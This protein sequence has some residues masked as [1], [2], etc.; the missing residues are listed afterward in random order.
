MDVD[1]SFSDHDDA[2][3]YLGEVAALW[4]V[5]VA[6]LLIVSFGIGAVRAIGG[7]AGLVGVMWRAGPLQRRAA[8]LVP[9]GAVSGARA[10]FRKGPRELAFRQLAYGSAPLREAVTTAQASPLWLAL[11]MAMLA[12]TVLA[13][14]LVVLDYLG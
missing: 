10:S 12:L 1:Y 6:A 8:A 7:I 9:D 4:G 2:R 3:K 11:R 5:W 14:A 13:F